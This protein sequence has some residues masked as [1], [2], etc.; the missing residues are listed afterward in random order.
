MSGTPELDRIFSALITPMRDD[1]SVN[2]DVLGALVEHQLD[3]GVEGFYCCGS[4]GEAPML[5]LEERKAIL[6]TVIDAAGGRV[7]VIAQVGTV[8]THDVVELARHAE[9]VGAT[10]VSLVPPYYYAFSPEEITAHVGAVVAGCEIPV[11]LYN[12][13]QFTGFTFDTATVSHLFDG[14]RVVGLKHTSH[15]LY[16]LERLRAAY[17]HKAFL[18][19][20]DETFLA[21]L[22][23]GASG[24][25]GTTV[26]AQPERFLRLRE[27]FNRGD[28]AAAQKIQR[29]IN[30]VVEGLVEHGIFPGVKYL[31]TLDGFESGSCRAPLRPL[32]AAGRVAVEKLHATLRGPGT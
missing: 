9:E 22:A 8:R 19:G 16:T 12:I 5:S 6:R 7:P 31:A 11:I 32:D 28:I 13:P 4:S 30:D 1:E 18:S 15:D 21:A 27:C 17:P 25:V 3:R 26:N 24:A 14:D 29:E 10:A 23:A 20:F 2:L